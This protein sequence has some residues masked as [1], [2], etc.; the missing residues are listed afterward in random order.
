MKQ[1]LLRITLSLGVFVFLWTSYAPIPVEAQTSRRT[2]SAYRTK[3]NKLDN[4]IVNDLPIP[5]LFGIKLKNITPNF[6][7]DRDGGERSHEGLDILAPKGAPIVSPTE[8]VV[9][10]T[11]TG[12]SSGNTVTTANPGGETF[13][14]MHLSEILVKSGDELDTGDLIGLVGNTGNAL[15][16]PTH[17]HF[18]VRDGGKA[19]DPYL[20]IT[21]EFSLEDKIQYLKNDLSTADDE[22]EFEDFIVKNYAAELKLAQTQSLKL[23]TVIE[24]KLQAAPTTTPLTVTPP[25]EAGLGSEGPLV[26]LIQNFLISKNTGVSARALAKATATGYFGPI[27]QSALI[28]YQKTHNIS[29]ASG[30]FGQTTL[31]Y[32]LTKETGK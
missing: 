16:G 17:L 2:S 7:D 6:G 9:I 11:G 24:K 32:M 25:G 19:T 4:E 21:K 3:I 8:A 20:R 10:R 31:T 30:Y 26:T 15:G 27:T 1:Q 5:I 29:P 22:D 12:D 14:Y 28:E 13:V 18:E 23:P